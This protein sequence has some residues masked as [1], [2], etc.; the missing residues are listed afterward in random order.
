MNVL[1]LYAEAGRLLPNLDGLL[2]DGGQLF[3][4]SLVANDR[5]VGDRYLDA[6]H[7]AGEFV[8]PRTSAALEKLLRDSLRR[9]VSYRTRGNMA[10]ATAAATPSTSV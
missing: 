9:P 2:A 1:H 8:R 4:T 5:L 3:L 7:R 10:F 6:L